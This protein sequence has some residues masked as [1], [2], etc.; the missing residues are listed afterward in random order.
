MENRITNEGQDL[1]QMLDERLAELMFKMSNDLPFETFKYDS[2]NFEEIFPEVIDGEIHYTVKRKEYR[3]PKQ[4]SIL[5]EHVYRA[6]IETLERGVEYDIKNHNNPEYATGYLAMC[7][8]LLRHVVANTKFTK[9]RFE[10]VFYPLARMG[11]ML[12]CFEPKFEEDERQFLIEQGEDP[13]KILEDAKLCHGSFVY[14]FDAYM[15]GAQT[16]LESLK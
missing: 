16:V 15:Q 7:V 14:A 13:N 12:S 6:K 3:D 5:N 4:I 2:F 10:G 1:E 11:T 9:D 8:E